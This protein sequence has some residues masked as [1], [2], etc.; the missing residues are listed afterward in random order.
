MVLFLVRGEHLNTNQNKTVTKLPDL[1]KVTLN[2][3]SRI[4][5][6]R[7]NK[8]VL[9]KSTLM[10]RMTKMILLNLKNVKKHISTAPK[11]RN[12]LK[13]CVP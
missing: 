12:I 10:M 9:I 8:T 1:T 5:V 3:I 7:N 13:R 4:A 6:N 2:R 11:L